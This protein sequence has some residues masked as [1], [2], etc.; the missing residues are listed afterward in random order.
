MA[1]YIGP[2]SKIARK[3]GEAIYG[4]DR[5]LEKK[6]Y[7]PGQHGLARKRKK[8]SEYGI[9][10]SEKQK[11][12]C[13]Y[14]VLEKQFVRTYQNA[15]RLEGITGENL[16]KLLE[17][18]LD[19]VV[20]RLGIAPT[21]AAARQLVSHRHIC[22]NGNV[23]NIPSYSL[24]AGDVVAVRE[25]SKSLEVITDSLAGG[26]KSRYSWLEWNDETMSGKFLQK[27]ERE[28]IPENIKEQLIVDLY[29]K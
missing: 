16:L 19:N 26:R 10:L 6:N 24:R 18:R 8:T 29:S 28:E 17:C 15:A 9:Q 22:V 23:V 21:R 3:F 5:V 20:Y 13:T 12:K 2:K 27:P 11:A 25:K 14:G 1:R 4:T 7:P